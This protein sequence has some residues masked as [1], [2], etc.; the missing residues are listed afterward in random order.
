MPVT[1]IVDMHAKPDKLDDVIQ[2]LTAMLPGTRAFDGC[3]AVSTVQAEDDPAHI[4]LVERWN[5]K[6]DQERYLAWRV[7]SG[8]TTALAEYFVGP[9]S[10]TYF[11]ELE[12]V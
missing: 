1:V 3:L 6:A 7:E 5:D 8:G 2:G 4:R 10:F 9:P 11:H 12:G